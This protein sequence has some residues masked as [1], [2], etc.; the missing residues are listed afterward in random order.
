MLE[1]FK[2]KH[3]IKICKGRTPDHIITYRAFAER[4]ASMA[5]L[6]KRVI[7]Y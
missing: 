6:V 5:V 7:E 1:L 3:I 4:I 2:N